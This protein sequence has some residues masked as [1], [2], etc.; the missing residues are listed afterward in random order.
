VDDF[1][2]AAQA[3]LEQAERLAREAD[4]LQQ[5]GTI[6]LAIEELLGDKASP[7]ISALYS[8]VAG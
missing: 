5:A 8:E 3:R 2:N 4:L 7:V 6:A 1:A